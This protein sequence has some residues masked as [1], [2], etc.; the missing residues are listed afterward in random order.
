M[1]VT[2][3]DGCC[4]P[5]NPGGNT[6]FGAVISKDGIE[7]KRLSMYSPAHPQNSNNVAE[8]KGL[9]CALEWL[10]ENGF[11][12]QKT[13]FYGDNMMT[14]RQMNGQW[15]AKSGMY[16]PHY[17]KARDIGKRFNN[18]K[19]IWI[20]REENGVADELSKAQLIKKK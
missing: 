16:I 19:F 4:E 20:P 15:K 5:R 10:L 2:Y 1:I 7:L 12:K 3:Y 14:V 9:T 17:L 18:L 13:I 6:G 8:Y 11:E